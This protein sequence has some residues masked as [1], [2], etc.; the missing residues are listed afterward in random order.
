MPCFLYFEF[1]LFYLPIS[2]Y[3][4]NYLISLSY[5]CGLANNHLYNL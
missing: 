3:K 2:N 1:A 5:L 4:E